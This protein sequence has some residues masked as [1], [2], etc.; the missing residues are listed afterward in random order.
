MSWGGGSSYVNAERVQTSYAHNVEKLTVAH[1][2][3]TMQLHYCLSFY[4]NEAK[5][6]FNFCHNQN[7]IKS[8]YTL[9]VV[10]KKQNLVCPTLKLTI[11]T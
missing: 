2:K 6:K 8:N 3:N 10:I 1:L 4:L 9:L 11:K 5:I 7:T